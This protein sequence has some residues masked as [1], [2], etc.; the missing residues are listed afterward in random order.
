M[1]FLL[2]STD[3]YF[4]HM[5]LYRIVMNSQNSYSFFSILYLVFVVSNCMSVSVK[6]RK[7]NVNQDKFLDQNWKKTDPYNISTDKQ[8]VY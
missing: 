1:V 3:K 4:L 6:Y 2:Y 8:E 5:L 7:N